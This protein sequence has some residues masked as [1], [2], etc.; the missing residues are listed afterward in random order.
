MIVDKPEF[1]EEL[2]Q[3]HSKEGD[4]STVAEKA[5]AIAFTHPDHVS[6]E[7]ED[8]DGLAPA[9]DML[10]LPGGAAV[11]TADM[12][13]AS[14][15][16]HTAVAPQE[17][18]KVSS[19][20]SKDVAK[21]PPA[22]VAP[23]KATAPAELRSQE[24]ASQPEVAPPSKSLQE[25]PAKEA[26]L[27]PSSI[28]TKT[29]APKPQVVETQKTVAREDPAARPEKTSGDKNALPVN[30]KAAA[31]EADPIPE[32]ATG[33]EG[34]DD[35][36]PIERPTANEGSEFPEKKTAQ[37]VANEAA[38]DIVTA[39]VTTI[40]LSRE[41]LRQ[42][43][44]APPFDGSADTPEQK[45]AAGRV[46][47]AYFEC[48]FSLL[49]AP[50]QEATELHPML[51]DIRQLQEEYEIAKDLFGVDS[52]EVTNIIEKIEIAKVRLYSNTHKNENE[53]ISRPKGEEWLK[54]PEYRTPAEHLESLCLRLFEPYGRKQRT[55]LLDIIEAGLNLAYE[56]AGYE[57]NPFAGP[58]TFSN[59]PI[60]SSSLP[61]APSLT[62]IR[63]ACKQIVWKGRGN[64]FRG[65]RVLS[66]LLDDLGNNL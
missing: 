2:E 7:P 8:S 36:P 20:A 29:P 34:G 49:T 65:K 32:L 57:V 4:A 9:T 40:R 6:I 38:E 33:N 17:A 18:P 58:P 47:N 51:E 66:K 12:K 25:R 60:R 28:E 55:F 31:E 30:E 62:K 50:W 27:P 43:P 16:E 14:P 45:A 21:V 5:V 23:V 39:V 46:D 35:E 52:P 48:D 15:N 26:S 44:P 63:S 19:E 59:S 53:R 56:R 41:Y 61:P 22:S 10:V 54:V 3:V 42:Y 37:E 1:S 13:T 24:Q 11:E 64:T